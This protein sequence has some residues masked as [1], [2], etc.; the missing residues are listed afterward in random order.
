MHTPFLVHDMGD[1]WE[2]GFR[3]LSAAETDTA[4]KHR[5]RHC[6]TNVPDKNINRSPGDQ[7]PKK[8]ATRCRSESRPFFWQGSLAQWRC[9]RSPR[10][11]FPTSA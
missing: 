11:F 1:V 4:S 2:M 7:L 5:S 3:S 6:A 8:R 9:S 10:V